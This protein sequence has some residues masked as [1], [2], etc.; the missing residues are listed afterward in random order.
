[1]FF[2]QKENI[3]WLFRDA[4]N[5]TRIF[6]LTGFT[7]GLQGILELENDRQKLGSGGLWGLMFIKITAVI[8]KW[9]RGQ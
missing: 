6:F 1:M 8:F 4:M 3:V 9:G 7:L 5:L 2:I